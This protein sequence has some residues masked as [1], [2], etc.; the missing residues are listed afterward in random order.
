MESISMQQNIAQIRKTLEELHHA[1]AIAVRE[2]DIRRD[3]WL[4]L[5]ACRLRRQLLQAQVWTTR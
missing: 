5:E 1:I 2:G 4:T 3:V